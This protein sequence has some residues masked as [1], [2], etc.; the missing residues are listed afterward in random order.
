MPKQ[1]WNCTHWLFC[2]WLSC[3]ASHCARQ[4]WLV[5]NFQSLM[6]LLSAPGSWIN[7]NLI[8]PPQ[9]LESYPTEWHFQHHQRY[10]WL[11]LGPGRQKTPS[12]GSLISFLWAK[13]WYS[14]NHAVQ[15]IIITA[16]LNWTH[17][18]FCLLIDSC[19]VRA[20][21]SKRPIIIHLCGI[22]FIGHS[23]LMI[24]ISKDL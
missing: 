16:Q 11:I 14:L 9:S 15:W 19:H 8:A 1:M 4:K 18:C 5:I 23:L 21:H 24:T 13:H 22:L 3:E 20:R 12:K 7:K 10:N 6:A 2:S 17:C